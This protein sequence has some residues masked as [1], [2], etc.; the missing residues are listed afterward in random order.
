MSNSTGHTPLSGNTYLVKIAPSDESI[1][2]GI[3]NVPTGT[4]DLDAVLEQ[5]MGFLLGYRNHPQRIA[6][7]M[8]GVGW[9]NSYV[10]GR[11][12]LD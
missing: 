3:A 6:A 5:L 2:Q 11:R 10:G 8:L 9:E 1:A 4:A 7:K 12:S